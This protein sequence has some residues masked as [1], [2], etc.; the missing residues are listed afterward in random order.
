[1]EE[2]LDKTRL[3]GDFID[4]HAKQFY[5]HCLITLLENFV[6]VESDL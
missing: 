2:G 3:K 5:R 6:Q 4:P 1:M